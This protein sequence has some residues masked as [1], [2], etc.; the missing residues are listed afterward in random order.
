MTLFPPS[1]I[2]ASPVAPLLRTWLALGLLALA[3]VPPARGYSEWIG[4]LPFWLAA[5]PLLMLAVAEHAQ[6]AA[7]VRALVARR[8]RLRGRR[9]QA[10]PLRARRFA[11]RPS[12]AA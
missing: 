3:L 9:P 1:R 6:V 5:A 8:R 4:W 11:R 7:L 12:H 10:R 2:A